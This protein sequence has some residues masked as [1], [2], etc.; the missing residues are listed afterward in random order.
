MDLYEV[1]LRDA[2]LHGANLQGAK[3]TGADLRDAKASR[4]T[5]WPEGFGEAE[6][7][8]AGVVLDTTLDVDEEPSE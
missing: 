1:D 8:A 5:I 7:R 6:Q 4:T 3:L 2:L